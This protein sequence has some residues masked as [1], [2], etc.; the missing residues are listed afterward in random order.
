MSERTHYEILEVPL[1]ATAE[2]VKQSYRRLAKRLHPDTN[3]ATDANEQFQALQLAYETLNDPAARAI[4]DAQIASELRRLHTNLALRL[5]PSHAKLQLMS[6]AQAVYVLAEIKSAATTELRRPRLNLCL[7][8]DRS[9]SME[10]VR[11]QQAREAANY[12]IDHIEPNDI[13][14]VIAFS[15]RAHLVIQ[16][17]VGMDRSAAKAAVNG[18]RPGGG[19]ELLQGVRAGLTQLQQNRTA[20]T[21]DQLILLTDG[22]TY[23]DEEG[24]LDAADLAAREKLGLTLLGLGHDWNDKLLDEMAVR[25]GGYSTYVD[26]PAKLVSVFQKQFA[27]LSQVLSRDLHITFNLS[28]QA[29]IKEAYRITPDIARIKL[30]ENVGL[31][32]MLEAN[33][34]IR[35]LIEVMTKTNMLGPMR[36]LRAQAS[37]EAIDSS[38]LRDAVDAELSLEISESVDAKLKPPEEIV[39]MLGRIAAFKV[40]EKAVQE[41]EKGDYMRATS[42]LKNLA[43]HLLNYGEVELSRSMLLEAG[44]VARTGRLSEEGRKRIHYGTRGLSQTALLSKDTK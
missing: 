27:N 22:Q 7:V 25:S 26:S 12:L 4:Y 18:I 30:H 11:L 37:G 36:I 39:D 35:L 1:T 32:G 33:R 20:N 13:L 29:E 19:T 16:G 15:D 8:M 38:A 34:P 40:Q 23:G 42:R 9:L 28:S 24:C 43:T 6:E 14:S 44:E 3:A 21:L 41:I 5:T 31:L 2:D 17:Q 10:G